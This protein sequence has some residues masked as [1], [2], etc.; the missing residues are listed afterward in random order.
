MNTSTPQSSWPGLSRPS[1]DMDRMWSSRIL[2]GVTPR[3]S[4]DNLAMDG[5]DKPGHDDLRFGAIKRGHGE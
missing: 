1:I 2:D 4:I 3:R 5:R